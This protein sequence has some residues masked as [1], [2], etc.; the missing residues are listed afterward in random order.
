MFN[1]IK[2]MIPG[3]RIYFI[4]LLFLFTF[5]A[6]SILLSGDGFCK[7]P[8]ESDH[9]VW[10]NIFFIN[11][12]FMGNGLFAISL[13]F[14]LVYRLRRIQEGFTLLIGFLLS[15]IVVQLI[16]NTWDLS[17]ATLYLEQG[18]YLFYNG[19]SFYRPFI[20]SGHTATAFTIVTVLV[21]FSKSNKFQLLLLVM[22]VLAGFSRMYLAGHPLGDIVNGALVGTVSGIVAVQFSMMKSNNLFIA[23]RNK[24]K[25]GYKAVSTPGENSLPLVQ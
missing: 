14:L 15:A 24:F 21:L 7:I 2:K 22:A 4:A 17:D 12:T 16:K 5:S 10:L 18:Q 6:I 25:K 3:T 19:K 9:P 20:I 11:Y 8:L 13:A 23:F 1:Q